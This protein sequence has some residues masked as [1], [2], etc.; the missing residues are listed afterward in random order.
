MQWLENKTTS[1]L[2]YDFLLL[3][4]AVEIPIVFVK[5]FVCLMMQSVCRG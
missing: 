2:L 5:G 3:E 4:L 1:I